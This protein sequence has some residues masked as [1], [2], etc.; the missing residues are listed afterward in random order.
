MN[1]QVQYD[2]GATFIFLFVILVISNITVIVRKA[3]SSFIKNKELKRIRDSKIKVSMAR[4]K[5][6][7]KVYAK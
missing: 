1:T 4:M 5:Y 3:V 7:Q 2:M 6:D